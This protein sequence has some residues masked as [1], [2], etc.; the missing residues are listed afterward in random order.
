M[1][2]SPLL[3][4]KL[5]SMQNEIQE[6]ETQRQYALNVLSQ[7]RIEKIDAEEEN[8]YWNDQ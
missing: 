1:E 3:E 6:I 5:R 4:S 7:L 2:Q 8:A